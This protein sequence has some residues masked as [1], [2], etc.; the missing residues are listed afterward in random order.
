MVELKKP[1]KTLKINKKYYNLW[2]ILMWYIEISFH[3]YQD[4][5]IK[6]LKWRD[7]TGNEKLTL[8]SNIDILNLFPQYPNGADV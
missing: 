8:F 6:I 1:F 7:L 2:E 4:K 5:D 3:F